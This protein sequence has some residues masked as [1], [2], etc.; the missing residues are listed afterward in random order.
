MPTTAKLIDQW[1]DLLPDAKRVASEAGAIHR[2]TRRL[3]SYEG[4]EALRKL[5]SDLDKVADTE[6]E[7]GSLV[8]RVRAVADSVGG[9]LENEWDRRAAGVA[10]EIAQFFVERQV[11]VEADVGGVYAPPLDIL[12]DPRNDRACLTYA[13]EPVKDRVPLA[14]ARVFR[15]W[16]NALARLRRDTI[17]PEQLAG[18]LV[19]AYDHVVR[20]RGLRPGG[21][22]RLPDV[23]FQMF[24]RRQ[25]AQ[26][27]QDP[28]RSRIKEYPRYQFAWD[29]AFL[30]DEP[31]W[32]ETP[33][34]RIVLHEAS[35]TAA[36]SRSSSICTQ[37][38]AGEQKLLSHL[39]V[40]R[41]G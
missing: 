37:T 8:S 13:D 19:D 21:R 27:R 4:Y 15:E 11:E 33:D 14:S 5:Q 7:V 40:E 30:L 9:W 38:E 35:E 16:E 36:R 3:A 2:I 12:I 23:H 26:V 28:R 1:L 41:T 6:L 29:L 17:P 34:L 20:L 32:L 18:L 10:E 39:H 22:A 31:S 25:S 24:M